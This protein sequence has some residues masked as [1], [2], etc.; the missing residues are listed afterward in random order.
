MKR[1]QVLAYLE[2]LS[3]FSESPGIQRE[4]KLLSYLGN[5]EK[6]YPVIHITGTNGKGSVGAMLSEVFSR[7][8]LKV[9]WFSS[10]HLE[11]YPERVRICGKEISWEEFGSVI[12][13][14]IEAVEKWQEEE[15]GKP[16]EF[17]VISAAG[18]YYF[19]KEQVD[20]A[21]IEVGIGGMLDSTNVV[22]PIFTI[23][24]NVEKD[25]LDKC[26]PTLEDVAIHKSGI[27][28]PSVP[29]VSAV[30]SGILR[31]II[32]NRAVELE[33]PSFFIEED[34]RFTGEANYENQKEILHF[35]PEDTLTSVFQGRYELNLLGEHQRENASVALGTLS[36]L[37]ERF[38][39]SK[40]IVYSALKGVKW[41][42]R[43]EVFATS[44]K[45][46]IIDGAHNVAGARSLRQTLDKWLRGKSVCFVAGFL[47]DKDAGEFV[48]ALH[49]DGDCWIGVKPDSPRG[50]AKEQNLAFLA[51]YGGIWGGA[52]EE[53]LSK[54][55]EKIPLMP[56]VVCGS[57]YL[58]GS[59]RRWAQNKLR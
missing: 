28:K 36:L 34:W 9:G 6:K 55:V 20:I 13:T 7:A 43:F 19:A 33:A 8:G 2:S 39:I 12:S 35:L 48:E 17:D 53:G 41:P 24:T 11:D 1:E 37:N 14:V 59:A 44:E 25:H 26:G 50:M 32:R 15:S 57:L 22:E 45:V 18:F 54:A 30:K 46:L 21:I 3:R 31:E 4:R 58:V 49:R 40:E 47:D 5:P 23:I 10:P 42:G 51:S 52:L 38:P 27:I 16:T 29:M 56:V